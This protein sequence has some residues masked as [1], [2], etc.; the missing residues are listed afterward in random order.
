M[1]RLYL[2]NGWN[3]VHGLGGLLTLWFLFF[4]LE[5]SLLGAVLCA[6]LPTLLKECG[7]WIARQYQVKWMF[8]AGFD[9]AGFDMRDVVMAIMG[10][11]IGLASMLIKVWSLL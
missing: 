7:D 9:P 4:I 5:W 1:I 2:S 10:T 3:T 6:F 11:M 8:I